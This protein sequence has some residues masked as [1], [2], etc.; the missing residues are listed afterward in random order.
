MNPTTVDMGGV[1]I[2]ENSS[3]GE[4]E[5][6]SPSSNAQQVRSHFRPYNPL[7]YEYRRSEI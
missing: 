7:G 5:V 2:E 6:I 4:Q 1:I 3:E